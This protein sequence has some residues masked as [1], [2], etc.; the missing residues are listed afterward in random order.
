MASV[1]VR[2]EQRIILFCN[3]VYVFLSSDDD[4]P[5]RVN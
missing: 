1:L 5:R 2:F 3:F 4:N